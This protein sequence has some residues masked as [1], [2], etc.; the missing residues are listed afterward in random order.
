MPITVSASTMVTGLSGLLCAADCGVSTFGPIEEADRPGA[1]NRTVTCV[2]ALTWPGM[3]RANS[4][5]RLCGFWTMPVTW[6]AGP[7]GWCQV[8][9]TV[10][11]NAE[12]TPWVRATWFA[13]VG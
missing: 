7:P 4:S 12:A 13:A 9:P 8:P 11:P 10:T 2:G 5:S 3:T 6:R 1:S